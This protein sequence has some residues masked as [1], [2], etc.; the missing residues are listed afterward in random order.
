MLAFVGCA[1]FEDKPL[2][3]TRVA[4][5][6]ESRS[7]AEAGLQ[8]FVSINLGRNVPAWP[9]S[10]WNLD[11]LTL[12]AI[13]FHPGLD[14]ARA[15][16]AVARASIR[17]AGA[18]PNPTVGVTPEYNISAASGVSPWAPGLSFD[19]PIETAG[20]RGHRVARASHLAEAARLQIVNQAWQVRSQ[21]RSALADYVGISTRLTLLQKRLEFQDQIVAMLEQRLAVGAVSV[22]EVAT[23]RVAATKWRTELAAERSRLGEAR[24]AIASAIGLPTKA[25]T[26]VEFRFD[27]AVEADASRRVDSVELRQ[28]AL[29]QRA[30]IRMALAEYVASQSALQLEIAKQ[31]PDVH[32]GPGYQWDQGE[33][34]WSLGLSVTLPVLNQNQGPIAEAEARRVEAAARFTAFQARIVAELD[35]AEAAWRTAQEQLRQT[36]ELVAVQAGQLSRL[37]VAQ[38][39]GGAD[40]LTVA[41]ARLEVAAVELLRHEAL[42]QAARAFN[43]VEAGLQRPIEFLE[44]TALGSTAAERSTAAKDSRSQ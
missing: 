15:Q 19:V 14:V 28:A 5:A 37:D 39:V 29:Q 18:R 16:W 23:A 26:G 7:L 4:E 34:K 35:H 25:V 13:Y 21:V 1:H 41:T 11:Q 3:P 6:L 10:E 2:V 36:D 32:F 9:P 44:T 20:K 22:N 31:W 33:G 17:S 42:V 43:E 27:L 30:D 12:A 38:A 40:R 8:D 24:A